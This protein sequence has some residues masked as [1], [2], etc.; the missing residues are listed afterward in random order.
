M[1]NEALQK[2]CRGYLTRL[3][4]LAEKH[5]LGDWIKE[6]KA[7]NKRKECEGSE[8]E[9]KMLARLVNDERATRAEI[10]HLLNKPQR[11][12]W[13]DSDYDKINKLKPLGIYDKVSALLLSSKIRKEQKKNLKNT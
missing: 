2:I 3:T 8:K 10:P 11:Q 13:E 9:V 4:Y 7:A 12:C 5:G 6:L 1:R